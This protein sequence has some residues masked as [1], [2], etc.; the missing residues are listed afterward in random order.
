MA[1]DHGNS[2]RQFTMA[3]SPSTHHHRSTAPPVV[4]A[5]VRLS[6]SGIEAH[7]E[8][9]HPRAAQQEIAH[10]RRAVVQRCNVVNHG[11]G[12]SMRVKCGDIV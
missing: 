3:I 9:L 4:M 6:G 12:L 1:V 10:L 2:L 5:P 7:S 8:A 11:E